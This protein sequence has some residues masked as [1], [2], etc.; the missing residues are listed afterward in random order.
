MHVRDVGL[1]DTGD[2]EILQRAR[3]EARTVITQD[4]DFGTLLATS[5][6]DRP[7]VVLLRMRDARSEAQSRVLLANLADLKGDLERGAIVVIGDDDIRVRRL[8]VA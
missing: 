8:P 1:R 6:A 7:S 4:T 3:D 5:R 2:S